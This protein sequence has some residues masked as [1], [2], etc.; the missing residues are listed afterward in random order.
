MSN[1]VNHILENLDFVGLPDQGIESGTDF[2]LP[3]S[4]D[5]MVV[6]FDTNA[7]SFHYCTHHA[8]DIRL[9]VNRGNR[10]ISPLYSRPVAGVA[11]SYSLELFQA[12][13]E[14]SIS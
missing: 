11:I 4:T 14:E 5:F 6:N 10:E 12:L 8:A 2:A 9:A 3:G 1:I 13:S 7:H